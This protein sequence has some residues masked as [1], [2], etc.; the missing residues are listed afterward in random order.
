MAAATGIPC[1][2]TVRTLH[3]FTRAV[4]AA[5]DTH[6]LTSIIAKVDAVGPSPWTDLALL[7]NRFEPEMA[8]TLMIDQC[9]LLVGLQG[10]AVSNARSSNCWMTDSSVVTRL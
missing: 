5:L 8:S 10:H 9:P 6:E 4:H 3:E 2:C 1:T 7:E